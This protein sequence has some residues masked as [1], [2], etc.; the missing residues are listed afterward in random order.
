MANKKNLKMNEDK[1][2]KW[3]KTKETPA[4]NTSMGQTG[5]RVDRY[6]SNNLLGTTNNSSGNFVDS[7]HGHN[8]SFNTGTQ[9][10]EIPIHNRPAT[11]DGTRG[12]P[13]WDTNIETKPQ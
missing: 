9:S 3:T 12:T 1:T 8:V 11:T 10:S 6:T 2:V 7:G 4:V 5:T 13:T